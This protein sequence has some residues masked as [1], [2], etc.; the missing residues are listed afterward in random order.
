MIDQLRTTI[1][2]LGEP[3]QALVS[4]ILLDPDFLNTFANAPAARSLHHAYVGGLLEHTLSMATIAQFLAGHYPYVNKDLLLSGV[5]IQN[6]CVE[7]V[8]ED[9]EIHR[10]EITQS[11]L[12]DLNPHGC[13]FHMVRPTRVVS[14][15]FVFTGGAA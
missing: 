9:L 8:A 3:W 12:H 14:V 1:A 7:L 2:A 13:V 5:L 4:H 15:R 11:H 6:L 10:T